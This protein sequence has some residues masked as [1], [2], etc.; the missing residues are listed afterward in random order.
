MFGPVRV[1]RARGEAYPT[2]EEGG[3]S[4]VS[5]GVLHLYLTH[6][7]EAHTPP[8]PPAADPDLVRDADAT[9]LYGILQ[10]RRLL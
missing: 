4:T 1:P 9:F 10:K 3:A 2:D 5:A 6:L 8:A 7:L